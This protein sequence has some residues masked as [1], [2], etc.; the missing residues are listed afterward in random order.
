MYASFR[1][2]HSTGT[3][4]LPPAF[5]PT[6]GRVS[7]A[8]RHY[9]RCLFATASVQDLLPAP[10]FQRRSSSCSCSTSPLCVGRPDQ[11]ARAVRPPYAWVVLTKFPKVTAA[12]RRE[13]SARLACK[14][15]RGGNCLGCRV[16]PLH[17]LWPH[18]CSCHLQGCSC[19]V[20]VPGCALQ[21]TPLLAWL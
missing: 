12:A 11:V 19:T 15:N 18:G 4:L 14:V 7:H 13:A 17:L 2:P 9:Q 10:H 6:C 3:C 1:I 8:G 20:P 5:V 16:R 21:V